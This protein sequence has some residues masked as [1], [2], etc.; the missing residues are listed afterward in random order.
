MDNGQSVIGIV[1][2]ALLIAL[3][4]VPGLFANLVEGLIE[5]T[6]NFRDQLI[7]G[8]PLPRPPRVQVRQPKWLAIVGAAL[9]GATLA[10]Q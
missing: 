9:I 7:H 5:G 2:G 4:I 6:L 8:Q 3:G 1:C 10:S